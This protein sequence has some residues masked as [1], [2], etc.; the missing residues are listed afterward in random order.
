LPTAS[1]IESRSRLQRLSEKISRLVEKENPELTEKKEERENLASKK[2]KRR[3]LRKSPL[4]K[5]LPNRRR[6][7]MRLLPSVKPEEEEELVKDNSDCIL[8]YQEQIISCA[9][10]NR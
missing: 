10:S 4:L 7:Q 2:N 9:F 5:K 6:L 3:L 8:R 1:R